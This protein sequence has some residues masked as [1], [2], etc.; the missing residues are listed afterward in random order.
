MRLCFVGKGEET[1]LDKRLMSVPLREEAIINKS[2]EFYN[3]SEPCMIHRSAVMKR[4]FFELGEFLQKCVQ[5]GAFL[6]EWSSLPDNF[7]SY[8]A[9]MDEVKYIR[10]VQE[11]NAIC[12]KN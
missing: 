5:E 12:R 7:K 4:L 8:L 10:L 3:D 6:L 11:D 2:I 1:I 9:M